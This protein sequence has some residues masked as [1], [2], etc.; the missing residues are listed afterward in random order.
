MEG[1]E[2]MKGMSEGMDK[3]DRKDEGVKRRNGQKNRK[4]GGVQ[5]ASGARYPG[6]AFLFFTFPASRPFDP[7][8]SVILSTPILLSLNPFYPFYLF[9]PF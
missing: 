6:R 4:D 1:T 3:K 5:G 7:S 8:I 9:H 2:G